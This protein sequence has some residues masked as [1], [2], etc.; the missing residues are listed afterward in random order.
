M[1]KAVFS[2]D[3]KYRY[4]LPRDFP[5][6]KGTVAF[7]LLNPS[8]ADDTK[9]D[10]TVRRCMGYAMHWGYR[11]LIV[12]NIFALRSTDPKALYLEKDPIGPDNDYWILKVCSEADL[13]VAGWGAHGVLDHRG[14]DVRHMLSNVRLK[15]LGK[16]KDGEP[17]HPLYLPGNAELVPL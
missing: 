13:V 17:K 10:P 12:I 1:S 9:N 2:P 3:L 11:K 8:T 14:F 16:T 15:C 4:T 7:T 5:T 6:G